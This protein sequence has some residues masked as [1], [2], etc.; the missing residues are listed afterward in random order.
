MLIDF[1]KSRE[2]KKI[3]FEKMKNNTVNLQVHYIPIHLQPYYRKNY[4]FKKGDFPI[5]E[6]RPNTTEKIDEE[7]HI[8]SF[9]YSTCF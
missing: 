2:S 7:Y 3:L 6:N 8:F 5:S 1:K 4:G 9:L